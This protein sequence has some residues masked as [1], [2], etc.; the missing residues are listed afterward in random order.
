MEGG[1]NASAGGGAIP[2]NQAAPLSY[3]GKLGLSLRCAP[4]PGD[5]PVDG[6][7]PLIQGPSGGSS[8]PITSCESG[9]FLSLEVAG[10]HTM[11]E[12]RGFWWWK[13][14]PVRHCIERKAAANTFC[15]LPCCTGFRAG[16][17]VSFDRHLQG[18]YCPGLWCISEPAFHR[19]EPAFPGLAGP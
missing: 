10:G 12:E 2:H 16:A 15:I 14:G 13:E 5:A 8:F 17:P 7:L 4:G 11:E 18:G 19:G 1:A 9:P 3:A 6:Q